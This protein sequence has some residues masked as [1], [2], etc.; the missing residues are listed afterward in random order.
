[1]DTIKL[2]LLGDPNRSNIRMLGKLFSG[3]AVFCLDYVDMMFLLNYHLGTDSIDW[4]F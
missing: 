3:N 4:S 1:M 2:R